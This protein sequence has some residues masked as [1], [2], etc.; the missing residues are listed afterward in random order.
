MITTNFYTF[1]ILAMSFVSF[2]M[3]CRAMYM[4]FEM[5]EEVEI[6]MKFFI[7]SIFTCIVGIL[8]MIKIIV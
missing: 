8:L 2:N 5:P 4:I 1:F 6:T 3:I 7:P